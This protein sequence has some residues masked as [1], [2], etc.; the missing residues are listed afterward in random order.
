MARPTAIDV[1]RAPGDGCSP[2]AELVNRRA[3]AEAS[4]L[5]DPNQRIGGR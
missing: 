5:D 1:A 3:H 2:G 4:G